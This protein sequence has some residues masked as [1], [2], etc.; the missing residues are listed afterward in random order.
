MPLKRNA[1]EALADAP[2]VQQRS[3]VLRRTGNEVPMQEGRDLWWHELTDG[4]R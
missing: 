3:V 2:G 4:E 1:D